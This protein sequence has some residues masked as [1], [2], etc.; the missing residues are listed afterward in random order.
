[1]YVV[2]YIVVYTN[3]LLILVTHK[4]AIYEVLINLCKNQ[5]RYFSLAHFYLECLMNYLQERALCIIYFRIQTGGWQS[6]C[7]VVYSRCF[8][9]FA[10]AVTI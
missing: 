8:E 4:Y 7:Y 5:Y 10:V 3:I 1:M 6:R 9:N 2:K